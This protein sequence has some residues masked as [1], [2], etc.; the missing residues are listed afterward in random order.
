[1]KSTCGGCMCHTQHSLSVCL[2]RTHTH[3][4]P[5]YMSKA[6]CL[7]CRAHHMCRHLK[8]ETCGWPAAQLPE[9]YIL[10]NVCVSAA[11]LKEMP[12]TCVQHP[13]VVQ[14]GHAGTLQLPLDG[15]LLIHVQDHHLR[16]RRTQ[17]STLRG[18]WCCYW[19][20]THVLELP[21]Y[22]RRA[23][24]PVTQPAPPPHMHTTV[25]RCCTHLEAG[26]RKVD[27]SRCVCVLLVQSDHLV[28]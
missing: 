3:T 28:V 1:M 12:S 7:L 5:M 18:C 14:V 17:H 4:R 22:T 13:A 19:V 16:Q 6:S 11:L 23:S 20:Q 9:V 8:S 15:R 25:R 21:A 24:V 26:P 2:Y 10:V 27:A